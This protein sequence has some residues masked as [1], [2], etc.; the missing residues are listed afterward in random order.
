MVIDTSAAI[1]ILL[2]EPEA[3][4]F[5]EAIA[6][7]ATRLMSAVSRVEA[8]ILIE[9]RKGVGGRESLE[10]LLKQIGISVVD[11]TDADAG[12]A[13]EGWRRYGKGNHPAR[14]NFADCCVYALCKASGEPLLFK[15]EDFSQTDLKF[16]L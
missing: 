5:C 2:A 13:L 9:A 7:D 15:G 3:D 4:R 8:G 16:V 14:L 1:A 6:E 10:V 11:F 12:R